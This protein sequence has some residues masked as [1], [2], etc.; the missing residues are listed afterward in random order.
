L[1]LKE[2]EVAR[3]RLPVKIAIIM[4]R[5]MGYLM[6][7]VKSLHQREPLNSTNT[8]ADVEGGI[9]YER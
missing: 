6:F 9:D 3:E 8:I 1:N 4:N 7:H 2:R 5:L